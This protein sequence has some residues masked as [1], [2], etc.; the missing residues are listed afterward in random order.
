MPRLSS[1]PIVSTVA[2]E[3]DHRRLSVPEDLPDRL[4]SIWAPVWKEFPQVAAAY[5]YGSAARGQPASDLDVG[6]LIRGGQP[7]ALAEQARLSRRLEETAPAALPVDVRP[8]S[9]EDVIFDMEVLSSGHRIYEGDREARVAFEASVF[10]RYQDIAP[11]M[12]RLRHAFARSFR[13]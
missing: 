6:L 1:R 8:L 7:L 2:L 4:R 12:E 10:S 5:L 3:P 9:D 11:V 13:R